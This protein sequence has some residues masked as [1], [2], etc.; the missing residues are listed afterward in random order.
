MGKHEATTTTTIPTTTPVAAPISTNGSC[1]LPSGVESLNITGTAHD[2]MMYVAAAC[3]AVTLLSAVGLICLHLCRYRVPKEQ[4]QIVRICLA[5]FV[6]AIVSWGQIYNYNFAAFINPIGNL[7][8]AFC[9]CALYLLYIQFAVPAATFNEDMF[10]AMADAADVPVKAKEGNWPKLGWVLVFQYPITETVAL[11]ILEATEAAEIYCSESLKPE[12]GHLWYSLISTIG[13]AL[14]V[15]AIFRFYG[16]MKRL[17]KARRGM[18]KLLCFKG[19]VFLRFV[20]TVSS[21]PSR[22]NTAGA[23]NVSCGCAD[24]LSQWIFSILMNKNALKTSTQFSYG[25]Q[26]PALPTLFCTRS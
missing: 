21:S 17:M 19:I 20:Q 13:V 18:W 1:P 6:F 4:R 9:L 26:T 11:I 14:C 10:T 5:P 8:E 15:M 3:A 25:E 24:S 12:F 2:P 16:R 7:Y 22:F 23:D